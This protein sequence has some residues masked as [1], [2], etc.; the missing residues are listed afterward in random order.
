MITAGPLARAH[1]LLK[2][3]NAPGSSLSSSWIMHIHSR[4]AAVR[5]AFQLATIP[6]FFSCRITLTPGIVLA[7]SAVPSVDPSSE[8]ITSSSGVACAQMVLSRAVTAFDRLYA[9]MAIVR[10][11]M[12]SDGCSVARLIGFPSEQL[13]QGIRGSKFLAYRGVSRQTNQRF[14]Q[15]ANAYRLV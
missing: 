6:W 8:T 15:V 4:E 7:C 5:H 12:S 14:A 1:A 11:M 3:S 2:A 9:G 13:Q 10:G